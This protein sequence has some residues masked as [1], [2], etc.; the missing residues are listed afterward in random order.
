MTTPKPKHPSPG[1]LSITDVTE[2]LEDKRGH[3]EYTLPETLPGTTDEEMRTGNF[4]VQPLPKDQPLHIFVPR[5]RLVV[6]GS[7]LI[8][9]GQKV[10]I[11][12]TDSALQGITIEENLGLT[13][14][15]HNDQE[16]RAVTFQSPLLVKGGILARKMPNAKPPCLTVRLG[17]QVEGSIKGLD[18]VKT[19]FG[20]I[21][22]KDSQEEPP[23]QQGQEIHVDSL[24]APSGNI[25]LPN[26]FVNAQTIET[27]RLEGGHV[28]VSNQLRVKEAG[29]GFLKLGPESR[30][31]LPEG[32]RHSDIRAAQ[33]IMVEGAEVSRNVR[34]RPPEGQE[35]GPDYGKV[36]PA[37]PA[38]DQSGKP[39]PRC[40][41]GHGAGA[42][43]RGG[44]ADGR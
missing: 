16:K 27:R 10:V 1:I 3:Y 22:G 32:A 26:G 2:G 28:D 6:D 11:R 15:N 29:I 9:H 20:G 43:G 35:L 37:Q 25:V 44:H 39:G 5:N 41:F 24:L 17:L 19:I 34:I 18:Q 30:V 7:F 31:L 36:V 38:A 23:S 40:P 13:G 12:G 8:N 21:R 33:Y 4:F 42:S 14:S